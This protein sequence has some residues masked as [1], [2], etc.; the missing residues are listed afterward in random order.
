MTD[1]NRFDLSA[2]T[3]RQMG[4]L[5][6]ASTLRDSSCW[7]LTQAELARSLGLTRQAIHAAA[8]A[9]HLN[10]SADGRIDARAAI[11]VLLARGSRPVQAALLSPVQS[12]LRVLESRCADLEQ[13]L[14]KA[15]RD[16]DESLNLQERFETALSELQ[17]V[18]RDHREPLAERPC[19]LVL[20]RIRTWAS[21]AEWADSEDGA[22]SLARALGLAPIPDDTEGDHAGESP[23]CAEVPPPAPKGG[24]D[25][26]SN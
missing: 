23:A 22:P 20:D 24:A 14:A 10:F 16:A 7:R 11:A 13:R 15:D 26:S 3:A 5:P 6:D 25:F 18:L 4:F 9:G 19:A 2:E 21:A 1:R 12:A 17:E 8:K